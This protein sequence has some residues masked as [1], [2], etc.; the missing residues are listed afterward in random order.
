MSKSTVNEK[1]R[2]STAGVIVIHC[3][4]SSRSSSPSLSSTTMTFLSA[5]SGFGLSN[6]VA[7]DGTGRLPGD[8]SLHGLVAGY[9]E[10]VEVTSRVS[11]AAKP[12]SLLYG[13]TK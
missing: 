4:P 11:L 5:M 9:L 12:L 3:R 7:D 13:F 6:G 8:S 1:I 2:E 10:N